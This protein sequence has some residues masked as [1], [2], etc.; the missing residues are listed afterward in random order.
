MTNNQ[1]TKSGL[2]DIIVAPLNKLVNWA[3]ATSP[4]YFQF[5]LACCAIEIMATEASRHDL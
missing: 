3:R 1:T 2:G 4:W 5:G